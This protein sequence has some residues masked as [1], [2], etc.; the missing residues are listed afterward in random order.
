MDDETNSNEINSAAI[1]ENEKI[2]ENGCDVA[3]DAENTVNELQDDKDGA[4]HSAELTETEKDDDE[5]V[6]DSLPEQPLP[7]GE[8]ASDTEQINAINSENPS[9]S[10]SEKEPIVSN[11]IIE[12]PKMESEKPTDEKNWSQMNDSSPEKSRSDEA[13][14]ILS[15]SEADCDDSLVNEKSWSQLNE[16]IGEGDAIYGEDSMD[17]EPDSEDDVDNEFIERSSPKVEPKLAPDC[18]VFE[19]TD[20]NSSVDVRSEGEDDIENEELGEEEEEEESGIYSF[21]HLISSFYQLSNAINRNFL[22]VYCFSFTIV[23]KITAKYITSKTAM[24]K[25]TVKKVKFKMYHR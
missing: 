9:E 22:I 4:D 25:V 20:D 12:S 7:A 8:P 18:P 16:S 6:S 15:T 24:K 1:D 10:C 17:D 14:L 21:Y 3:N 13:C 11:D 5:K 23:A 19:L 2:N